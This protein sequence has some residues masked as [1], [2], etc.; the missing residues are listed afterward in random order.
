MCLCS[1]TWDV[2]GRCCRF[3]DV[4]ESK[5]GLWVRAAGWGDG[6]LLETGAHFFQPLISLKDHLLTIR[7]E[8]LCSF[9]LFLSTVPPLIY[10]THT[11]THTHGGYG[12]K[13]IKYEF[14]KMCF[15][16]NCSVTVWCVLDFKQ[17]LSMSEIF[18]F[19][20]LEINCSSHTK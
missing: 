15:D 4:M 8:R 6:G 19:F 18:F 20:F 2:Q 16:E 7:P 12:T 1:F 5:T 11:H 17:T 13:V 3:G 9:F 10:L 14:K